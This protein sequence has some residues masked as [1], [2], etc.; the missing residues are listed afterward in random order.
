M[1]DP[2]PDTTDTSPEAVMALALARDRTSPPDEAV[3]DK[4]DKAKAR[5]L[6]SALRAAGWRVLR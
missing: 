5:R 6:L 3:P 2:V 1:S 4:H